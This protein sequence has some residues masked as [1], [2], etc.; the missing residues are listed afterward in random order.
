MKNS[1]DYLFFKVSRF[2]SKS[3]QGFDLAVLTSFVLT[4]FP[5]LHFLTI[6]NIM[7][8][9]GILNKPIIE[10]SEVIIIMSIIS[11]PLFVYF[12]YGKRHEVIEKKYI[13]E[14]YEEEYKGRRNVI[15]YMTISFFIM[16]VTSST[17]ESSINA[18]RAKTNHIKNI[19]LPK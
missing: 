8:L 9:L 4:I 6:I 10:K 12:L 19:E 16:V 18:I 1:V 15:L 17:R 7:V 13:N 3:Q 14:T 11:V 2:F 5:F